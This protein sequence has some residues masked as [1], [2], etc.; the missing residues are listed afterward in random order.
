MS[1]VRL[2]EKTYKNGLLKQLMAYNKKA[3]LLMQAYKRLS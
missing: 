3:I 1:F 2:F